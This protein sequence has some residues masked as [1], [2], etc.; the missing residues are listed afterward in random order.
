MC[1]IT[2]REFRQNM[3]GMLDRSAAGEQIIV[4][5]RGQ[6]FIVLPFDVEPK[7]TPQME[8]KIEKAREQY[9][10]GEYTSLRSHEEI[11]KYLESL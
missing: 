5:R 1:T 8:A 7:V 11:D 3:A 2:T 6:Y 4:N 9:H 10:K